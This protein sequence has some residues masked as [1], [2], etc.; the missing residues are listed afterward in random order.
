MITR[1]VVACEFSHLSSLL[2]A[3]V[4]TGD[5]WGEGGGGGRRDDG[6]VFEG[7]V[8]ARKSGFH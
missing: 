4:T 2:A 6:T 1:W 8:G 3:D 5:R 7:Q